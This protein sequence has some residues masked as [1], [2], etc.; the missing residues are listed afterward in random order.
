MALTSVGYP[1]TDGNL[2]V[3]AVQWAQ[4][5]A[6]LGSVYGVRTANDLAVTPVAGGVSVA[7][8][9]AFGR[10]ITDT[11]D[12][13]QAVTIDAPSSG[14]TYWLVVLRRSWQ[15]VNTSTLLAISLGTSLPAAI[16][17]S[18]TR[19]T[20]PGIEDDQP[21]ALVQMTAGSTA[22]V[23]NRDLRLIGGGPSQVAFSTMTLDLV[24]RPGQRVRIGSDEWVCGVTSG[25]AAWSK[26]SQDVQTYSPAVTMW[27]GGTVV[28]RYVLDG[29]VCTGFLEVRG[30]TFSGNAIFPL[31]VQPLYL[32]WAAPVA[33]GALRKSSNVYPLL[34]QSVSGDGSQ[35]GAWFPNGLSP[36]TRLGVNANT[37]GASDTVRMNF[38]YVIA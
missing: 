10:G 38:G 29:K 16:P 3:T 34:F 5:A 4:L 15:A 2:A 19:K 22:G 30:G 27:G 14:S 37:L 9:V 18:P 26:A 31:P 24:K 1:R 7:A 17:N 28:G 6:D 8:G 23:I 35:M 36:A 13:A 33:Y 11:L 21:L 25:A 32:E 20:S 12:S